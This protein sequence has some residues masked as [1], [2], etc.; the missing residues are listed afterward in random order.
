MMASMNL[1]VHH[2]GIACQDMSATREFVRSTH[3]IVSDSGVVR[4]PLQKADVCLLGTAQ[5]IHIEL[6]SG[7]MVSNVLRKGMS[8]YHECCEVPG[9]EAAISEL[10][11]KGCVVASGPAPAVLFGGRRVAFLVTPM[12]LL[13]LLESC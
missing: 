5:G 7:E 8:Y 1:K 13:E 12:G 4:D 6:V 3:E 9:L 11:A 10:A 2:I